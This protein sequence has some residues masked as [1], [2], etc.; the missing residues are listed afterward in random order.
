MAM[1][2]L[3]QSITRLEEDYATVTSGKLLL[4]G[5]ELMAFPGSAA[6]VVR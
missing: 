3:S 1:A 5:Q 2:L 4:C 6:H